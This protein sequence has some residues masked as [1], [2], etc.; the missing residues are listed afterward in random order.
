MGAINTFAD[1]QYKIWI[2]EKAM[3]AKAN[4]IYEK[5]GRNCQCVDKSD[6]HILNT[7]LYFLPNGYYEPY[8][9]INWPLVE[10]TE[11]C[12]QELLESKEFRNLLKAYKTEEYSIETHRFHKSRWDGR[13]F[14]RQKGWEMKQYRLRIRIGENSSMYQKNTWLY[15][16][17]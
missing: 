13:K 1:E 2:C 8:E 4:E 17:L 9:E 3:F 14:I 7:V 16:K 11:T 15:T 10:E 12:V 6:S 5:T